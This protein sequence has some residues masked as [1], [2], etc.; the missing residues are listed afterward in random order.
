MATTT[1]ATSTATT[2]SSAL[3]LGRLVHLEWKVGVTVAN[4]HC[5]RLNSPFVRLCFHIADENEIVTS[6][7]FQLT[8]PE[9]EVCHHILINIIFQSF[10]QFFKIISHSFHL[11]LF[12]FISHVRNSRE[13]LKTLLLLSNSLFLVFFSVTF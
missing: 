12:F 4:S 1:A 8:I 2:P 9:F 5:K 11:D 13:T 10:P 6:H 3:K 7:S